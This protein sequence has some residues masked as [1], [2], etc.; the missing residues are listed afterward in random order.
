MRIRRFH[1]RTSAEAMAR[2]KAALGADALVLGSEALPEGGIEILAAVDIEERAGEAVVQRLPATTGSASGS[3]ENRALRSELRG[4]SGRLERMR[5]AILEAAPHGAENSSA[6]QLISRLAS[7]GFTGG[8]A[9]RV[10][11][12]VRSETLDGNLPEDAIALSLTRLLAAPR[13]QSAART[14]V[15]IGAP[16]SGKTTTAGRL[17][18]HHLLSSGAEEALLVSLDNRKVGAAEE[19][20]AWARALRVDFC[21]PH[22]PGAFGDLLERTNAGFVVVDTPGVDASH[23]LEHTLCHAREPICVTVVVSAAMSRAALARTWGQL[24]HLEPTEAIVTHLDA[25][26]EPGL[27]LGW[28]ESV[29]VRVSWLASGRS[30]LEGFEPM[31]TKGILERL[32]AA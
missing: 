31:D 10:A 5:R 3:D 8:L 14:R 22:D 19:A 13:G 16:G 24:A 15:L 26:D 18:A 28:L 30:A 20:R 11:A 12:E 21:A 7:L 25:T 27:V 6:D 23:E 9:A 4:I 2:L 32:R 17:I 29:G 1:G